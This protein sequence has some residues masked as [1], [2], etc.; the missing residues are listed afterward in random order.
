MKYRKFGR[1]DWQ[2]SVLGF[3]CMRL[4]LTDPED[5]S[6]I[7]E[8]RASAMIYHAIE[9]G[10]NYLDSAYGYH[11]QQSERFL[12]KALQGGWRE[13][14]HLATKSPIWILENEGDFEKKLDE[15]LEKLQTSAVDHYLL[16]GLGADSWEKV[17]RL[18]VLKYAQKALDD[19][20]VHSLGFSFHDEYKV[21]KEIVDSFDWTFCQIQYNYMDIQNQAGRRGLRYAASKGLAVVVMEPLLGG[22]LVK[23]PPL[24]QKVWQGAP[25]QRTPADWALQWLWDQPEVTVVLS[26]M[27]TLQQVQEN[28]AIADR[29]AVGSLTTSEKALVT[30]VR[31]IYKSLSPIPCTQ[32]E[33]CLPCPH[34][35][36]IPR[37][38]A[39]YNEG[40]MYDA[41]DQARG[42][43]LRWMR[44]EERASECQNC[45]ECEPKC[46]Q[47]ILI[48]E[49][50]PKVHAV[51]GEG[52]AY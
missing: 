31:S 22:K 49:W 3:G 17:K 33:Y 20:R 7:D 2:A 37:N 21:F 45:D 40:A 52:Q 8:E 51:L 48:S 50:M 6:S 18:S 47:H 11:H 12:G 23:A 10:V 24:V 34:G 35:I 26:G 15:Q 28:L 41:L 4:P 9:Q 38:F 42:A 29:S 1:L 36:A 14:V 16:H 43:Y 27:N 13:R 19:G 30:K 39:I 46:P 44:P 32:C 5:S 25:I